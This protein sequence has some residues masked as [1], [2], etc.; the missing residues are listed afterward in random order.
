[1]NKSQIRITE[2]RKIPL[3][4]RIHRCAVNKY[5]SSLYKFKHSASE[6]GTHQQGNAL[7]M[8]EPT[9][10][11]FFKLGTL[12]T[13]TLFTKVRKRRRKSR[14]LQKIFI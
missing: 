7:N 11:E 13:Y 1:M 5:S 6:N 2:C 14:Q 10:S 8:K 4:E 3:S 9:E 12:K